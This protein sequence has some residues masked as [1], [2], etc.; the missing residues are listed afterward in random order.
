MSIYTTYPGDVKHDTPS[1]VDP[2]MVER[3]ALAISYVTEAPQPRS[4]EMARAAIAAMREPTDAII[5]AGGQY[6]YAAS[7]ADRWRAMIDCALAEARP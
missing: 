2:S 5:N 3:V 7:M 4:R 1:L 6:F